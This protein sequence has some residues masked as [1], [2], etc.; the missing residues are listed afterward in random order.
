MRFPIPRFSFFGGSTKITAHYQVHRSYWLSPSVDTLRFET[1]ESLS[2]MEIK[3][4]YIELITHAALT[5][6]ACYDANRAAEA[7]TV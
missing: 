5:N 2:G 7:W 4:S 3:Q 6:V 1:A